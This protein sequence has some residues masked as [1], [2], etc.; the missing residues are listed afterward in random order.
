METQSEINP[1]ISKQLYSYAKYL[2]SKDRNC[3][4]NEY[5]L[6]DE[7][8]DF[9]SE[10]IPKIKNE[11]CK[12]FYKGLRTK[13]IPF[14]HF[15]NKENGEE[16]P[17]ENIIN[18]MYR[19]ANEQTEKSCSVCN[20]VKSTHHFTLDKRSNTYKKQCKKCRAKIQTNRNNK[21]NPIMEKIHLNGNGK[22]KELPI[23]KIISENHIPQLMNEGEMIYRLKESG[24][25]IYK[26]IPPHYQEC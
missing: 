13:A 17:I 10:D 7:S 5:D 9:K 16:I 8:W 25:I 1:E 23:K 22:T 19:E 6:I 11:M 4:F 21:S 15:K 24:Y 18:K 3:I 26:I 2:L 14:S 12:V 20:E